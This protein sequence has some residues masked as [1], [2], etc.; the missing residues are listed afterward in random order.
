MWNLFCGRIAT[1][2]AAGLALACGRAHAADGYA[3]LPQAVTSF[4]AVTSGGWLYVFGGHMGERHHY[5]SNEVS[6]AFYRLNLAGGREWEALPPGEASQSPVLVADADYLYRVGGMAARN[7]KGQTNDLWSHESVARFDVAVKKWEAL[8]AL[9]QAR[10]SDDGWI[11]GRTL[12][13]VGGWKL[14]GN[15]ARPVWAGNGVGAGPGRSG[16]GVAHNSPAF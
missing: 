10:S 4:G 6:G 1:G 14:A 15:A 11:V 8:A 5:S 2:V 7:P 3:P 16:G 12:Y 13:V 9:P